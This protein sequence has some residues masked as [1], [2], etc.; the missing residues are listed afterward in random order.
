MSVINNNILINWFSHVGSTSTQTAVKC[1][2]TM[3][4][5]Y[6]TF[7]TVHKG[8]N[9]DTTSSDPISWRAFCVYKLNLSQVTYRSFYAIPNTFITIGY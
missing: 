5:A 7:Y 2:V 1:T 6:K 4:H 3:P 8:M 9:R